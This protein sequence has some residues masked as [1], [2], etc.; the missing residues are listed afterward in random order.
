MT[1]EE[2][3]AGEQKTEIHIHRSGR[4]LP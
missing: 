1:L 4:I 3:S 2:F